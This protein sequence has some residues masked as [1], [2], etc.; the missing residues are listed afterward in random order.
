MKFEELVDLDKQHKA[1]CDALKKIANF[2]LEKNLSEE[3]VSLEE[4]MDEG[5]LLDWYISSVSSQ[6]EPIWTE[7]HIKELLN[8]YYVIPKEV[9]KIS[10]DK[11]LGVNFP[12]AVGDTIYYVR[13]YAD[14]K[15]EIFEEWLVNRIDI[16][17][18]KI[19]FRLTHEGTNDYNTALEKEFGTYWFADKEQAKKHLKKLKGEIQ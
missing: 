1:N 6:D 12:C 4:T 16:Y 18:D 10:K 2:M 7:E 5:T 13:Y 17:A 3:Y 14:A 9:E 11:L 15:L 8:D 19:I